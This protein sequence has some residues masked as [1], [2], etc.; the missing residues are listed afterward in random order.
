MWVGS[1]ERDHWHIAGDRLPTKALTNR[2]LSKVDV[3][4]SRRDRD[5]ETYTRVS[6]MPSERS[7]G[8]GQMARRWR[9]VPRLVD[10]GHHRGALA[11]YTYTYLPTVTRPP[12]VDPAP[13]SSSES[14]PPPW[15]PTP[16]ARFPLGQ[17]AWP[18][19]CFR[20]SAPSARL[21]CTKMC[22]AKASAT[23]HP[24]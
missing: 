4:R 18:P 21:S 6:A 9:M 1:R 13:L 23:A 5:A 20:R 17:R 24:A 16:T 11:A 15:P 3:H 14:R 2:H 12:R 22:H 7:F 10:P 8:W 19:R